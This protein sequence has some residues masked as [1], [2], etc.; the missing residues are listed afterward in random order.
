[1]S[2]DVENETKYCGLGEDHDPHPWVD[3][4]GGAY[5]CVLPEGVEHSLGS[6]ICRGAALPSLAGKWQR[7]G[8]RGPEAVIWEDLDEHSGTGSLDD[9]FEVRV[10]PTMERVPLHRIVGRSLV[11]H[12]W[13]VSGFECY[14]D[15]TGVPTFHARDASSGSYGGHA[16]FTVSSEGMVE[17]QPFEGSPPDWWTDADQA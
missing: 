6:L 7:R 8:W 11:G 5:E 16:E 1:M 14:P 12:V 17:V 15:G 2:V 13:T 10:R 3:S 9:L 4:S